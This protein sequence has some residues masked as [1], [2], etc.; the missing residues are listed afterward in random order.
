VLVGA[1]TKVLDSLSGVLGSTE[2]ERVA[3]S[4]S[5]QGQLVESQSLS[6]SGNDAST[7]GGSE[8]KGSNADLGDGQETVV[9]RD[10]ANNDDGLVV[11]LLGDVCHY[12][13]Q[14]NWGSVDARHEE[15]AQDNLVEGGVGTT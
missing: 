9:I 15:T 2:K 7:S 10:S 13:G 1:E 4:G 5:P 11:G 8:A 12:S 3:T 6:A 14:R